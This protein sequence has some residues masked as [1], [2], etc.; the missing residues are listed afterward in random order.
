VRDDRSRITAAAN[1]VL[2][3]G[4]LLNLIALV[5]FFYHYSW[6]GDR[7]FASAI[8]PTVYYAL[9]ALVSLLLF[10][11]LLLKPAVKENLALL[12]FST[13]L[14]LVCAEFALEALKPKHTTLW[15]PTT[16]QDIDE[17]VGLARQFGV[18]YDTRTQLQVVR[19]LRLKGVNAVPAVYPFGFLARQPD[20]ALKSQLTINNVEILPLSGSSERLT[21]F[22]NESGQW[23]TYQSDEQGFHNPRGIWG[24]EVIDIAVLGDS[25]TQGACVPSDRNF[26]AGIRARYPATLNLGNSNKGPLM[27]LADLREYAAAFKPRVVLW[28]FYEENDFGDLSRESESPLLMRYRNRHFAQD[29]LRLRADLDRALEHR[30]VT[31]LERVQTNW[32]DEENSII[33]AVLRFSNLRRGLG[34]M[35]RPI[36]RQVEVRQTINLL[37]ELLLE[38]KV[39]VDSWGGRLYLVYLPERER[40]V[41]PRTARL[42]EWKRDQVLS[43]ARSCGLEIIDVHAAFQSTDDP[44]G[45]FPFRRRGHYNEEGHRLVAKTVLQSISVP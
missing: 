11:S 14:S 17:L 24:S 9:P 20:G 12:L 36:D 8:G 15:T 1:L 42:D 29:L 5:Y 27:S 30:W 2:T 26:V 34:L 6:L 38:A 31:S 21:V 19:D 16:K 10:S 45:L 32:P 37:A 18:E 13:G 39:T 7:H 3:G 25:Y 33:P 22:C 43:V 23:I 44:L 28:F 41:E 4:G 35:K 40:Y